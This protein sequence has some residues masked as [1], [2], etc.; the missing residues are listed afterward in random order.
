V[1]AERGRPFSARARRALAAVVAVA[2]LAIAATALAVSHRGGSNRTGVA[3]GH[4]TTAGLA[5]FHTALAARLR[6]E[7]LNWSW[8]A[9]V[10]SGKTFDGVAVV[11]CNV[12]FGMDPH[13]EAYCSVFNNGRLLTNFDDAAIPCGH[14]NAGYTTTVVQYGG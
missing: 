3:T 12:D 6:S 2:A 9:C 13:V 10:H 14:D 8:I 4:V 1:S 7:N 5:R 11:R